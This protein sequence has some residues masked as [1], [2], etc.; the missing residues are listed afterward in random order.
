[1]G[2]F[3]LEWEALPIWEIIEQV[4]AEFSMMAVKQNTSL[5]LDMSPLVDKGS[6]EIDIESKATAAAMLPSSVLDQILVGDD[7]RL[8]QVLRNLLSNAIKF[9]KNRSVTV[10]VS[11]RDHPSHISTKMV[12]KPTKEFKMVDG[13]RKSFTGS[14]RIVVDVVDTDVGMTPMQLDTV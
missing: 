4:T 7:Q 5:R 11:L 1:M 12:A 2:S 10:K 3:K 8:R 6:S 13:T 9:S 14:G